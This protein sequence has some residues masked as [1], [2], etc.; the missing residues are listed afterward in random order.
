MKTTLP[1]LALLF[2]AGLLFEAC[3]AVPTAP[4]SAEVMIAN[5]VEDAISIGLVPVLAKNPSYAAAAQAA[6]SAL[7]SF[8]GATITPADVDSLIAKTKLAPEDAKTVAALVN[9]SW[10]TYVRR[11]QQRAGA[12]LR[13]DVKLFLE[14]VAAGINNAAASVPRT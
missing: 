3:T 11:Y 6:A 7:G 9:A 5:A 10:N 13:P 8:S 4:T 1:I 2:A 14:A 12:S